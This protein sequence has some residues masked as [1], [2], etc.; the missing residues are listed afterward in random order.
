MCTIGKN[1]E[2][3]TYF[4]GYS[5]SFEDL[6]PLWTEGI[7]QIKGYQFWGVDDAM[8]MI[9]LDN[10]DFLE[11]HIPEN[12]RSCENEKWESNKDLT[13]VLKNVG[14]L[15]LLLLGRLLNAGDIDEL[16]DDDEDD[17]DPESSKNPAPNT[18]GSVGLLVR[19]V[20]HD[21]KTM[22]QRLGVCI[23]PLLDSEKEVWAARKY[24]LA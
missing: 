13:N 15:R 18:T 17:D 8:Q 1:Q 22:W 6:V 24:P 21:G 16:D 3:T 11:Q 10:T 23:W 9:V 5:A 4:S 20:S 12:L 14:G 19:S 2:E 7:A